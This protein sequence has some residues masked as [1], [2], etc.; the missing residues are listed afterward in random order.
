MSSPISIPWYNLEGWLTRSTAPASIKPS[1]ITP[2]PTYDGLRD[3]PGVSSS[4][5]RVAFDKIILKD[6]FPPRTPLTAPIDTKG[7]T[8]FLF[9]VKDKDADPNHTNW[10]E[11]EVAGMHIARQALLKRSSE[12]GALVPN[13]YAWR[14]EEHH[15]GSGCIIMED[16]PGKPLS[17]IVRHADATKRK[18]VLKAFGSILRVIHA[19]PLPECL[20]TFGGLTVKNEMRQPSYIT[21]VDFVDD[22][23][24]TRD[25]NSFII[26]GRMAGFHAN[27]GPW[28][29]PWDYWKA[30]LGRQ[31]RYADESPVLQGWRIGTNSRKTILPFLPAKPYNPHPKGHKVLNKRSLVC[32][33]L[34]ECSA[35][36][37]NIR[38][39]TQSR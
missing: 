19:A 18:A 17:D 5:Y 26:G 21:G 15:P 8:S 24:W 37:P 30:R 31:M 25:E 27:A 1:T 7:V 9:K 34:S 2:V 14:S 28:N 10:V 35:R 16:K 23:F 38:S 3:A 33:K 39:N 11:N 36:W 6:T 32:P 20:R 29:R 4:L 22:W 12:A 13:V